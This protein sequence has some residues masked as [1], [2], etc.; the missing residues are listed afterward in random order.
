M[1]TPSQDQLLR[2]DHVSRRFAQKGRKQQIPVVDDVSFSLPSDRPVILAIA[3]ESGSGKST[4]AS[5]LLGFLAPSDGEISF[6]GDNVARLTAKQRAEY[7]RMVQAVFQDPF[8]AFNPFYPVEHALKLAVEKFSLAKT[9]AEAAALIDTALRNVRLKPEATLG[10]YPHQLSGGQLQRVMIA[11]A[12]MIHPRL[13]VADEPVSMIDASLRAIV[14]EIMASLRDEHGI[15]QVY[16]THDLS[17]A[18]QI[19]DEILILYRGMVVER[20]DAEA[21]IESPKHPYTQLLISSIP[22]PDPHQKWSAVL[23]ERDVIQQEPGEAPGCKFIDRCPHRM[24]VCAE[25]RPPDFVVGPNQHAACF[26]YAEGVAD[27]P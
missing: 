10:R 26:L 27:K 2:V 16:I 17:S 3:G 24:P 7:R 18:L 13:I 25:R 23:D 11:R 21:V 22:V 4:L 9:A 6:A 12:L 5:M 14:L 20:G 19:S 15:S 1:S 8:D